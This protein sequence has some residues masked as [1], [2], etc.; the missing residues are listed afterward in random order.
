M[1]MQ[2]VLEAYAGKSPELIKCEGYLREIISSIRKDY[3]S[4]IA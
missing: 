2:R 3:D 4:G 1:I